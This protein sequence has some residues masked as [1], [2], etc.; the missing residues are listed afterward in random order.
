MIEKQEKKIVFDEKENSFNTTENVVIMI[1]L[2]RHKI[3]MNKY[4]ARTSFDFFNYYQFDEYMSSSI[5]ILSASSLSLCDISRVL[6]FS[7]QE[8]P[9]KQDCI[10]IVNNSIYNYIDN[11]RSVIEE[12]KPFQCYPD[13]YYDISSE[14]IL[15]YQKVVQE[16][17]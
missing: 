14:I 10:K 7:K 4:I 1:K 15:S 12:L 9:Y 11:N 3:K 13:Q 16:Y 5:E 2:L 17:R 6:V 8:T